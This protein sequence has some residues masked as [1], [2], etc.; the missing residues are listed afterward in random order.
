MCII[1]G[2]VHCK[3]VVLVFR[4]RSVARD[5]DVQVGL[6]IRCTPFSSSPKP[7]T[8]Y[9]FALSPIYA[10]TYN[11]ITSGDVDSFL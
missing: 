8:D 1:N 5:S 7:V 3:F 10:N 4:Q 2:A 6:N 11:N 9:A